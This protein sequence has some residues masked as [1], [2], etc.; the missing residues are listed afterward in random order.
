MM[1]ASE[2]GDNKTV[3]T[4]PLGENDARNGETHAAE[5]YETVQL[6]ACDKGTTDA[7]QEDALGKES[8]TEYDISSKN[9]KEGGAAVPQSP[10]VSEIT[11]VEDDDKPQYFESSA[12]IRIL[13]SDPKKAEEVSKLGIRTTFVSYCIQSET[14]LAEYPF[15]KRA[16][17]RRF[18]DFDVSDVTAGRGLE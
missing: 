5:E 8:W 15:T 14:S 7:L 1:S 2:E 10:A 11:P 12:P 13:V 18:K 6:E 4:V 17:W 9:L 16:V 3:S